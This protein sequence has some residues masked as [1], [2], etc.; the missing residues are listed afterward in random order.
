MGLYQSTGQT[1]GIKRN[2]ERDR[3]IESLSRT[4]CE[5]LYEAAKMDPATFHCYEMIVIDSGNTHGDS[6]KAVFHPRENR[7][8]F[9]QNVE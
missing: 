3:V 9:T 7:Y 6:W 4:E 2:A 1:Y 8:L 5:A